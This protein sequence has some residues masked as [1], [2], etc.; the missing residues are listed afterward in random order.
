MSVI[1]VAGRRYAANLCWLERVGR[2]DT[3]RTAEQLQRHWLV[4]RGKRTGFAAWDASGCPD[5]LPALSLA[6]MALIGGGRWVA[7]LEGAATDGGALYALVRARDGAVLVG[8]EEIFSDREMALEAFDGA[9]APGWALHATPGLS[10][11]LQGEGF[12]IAELDPDALG[13]AAS[14]AGDAIVLARPAPAR[15]V[16]REL[17]VAAV[18]SLA[19]IGF[20]TLVAAG[21]VWMERDALIEEPVGTPMLS[22]P[23]FGPH[24]FTPYQPPAAPPPA[25]R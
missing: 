9:R 1:S 5:G 12:E 21:W 15:G 7:L 19:G 25:D 3:A 20:W 16:W 14:R 2:R 4:H 23:P 6:L 22:V 18:A 17:R 13:E 8:G 11:A 10:G 24:D